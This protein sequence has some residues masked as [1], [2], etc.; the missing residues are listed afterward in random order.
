MQLQLVL[1]L[2]ATPVHW[3]ALGW[4]WS[5]HGLTPDHQPIL[6]AAHLFQG[7]LPA[8]LWWGMAQR[9]SGRSGECRQW[10]R[11]VR[12]SELQYNKSIISSANKAIL[13]T[14]GA[15][16]LNHILRINIH[17]VCVCVC[18]RARACVRACVRAR[19]RW[20]DNIKTDL[21]ETG[22]EG[23]EWP[24]LAHGRDNWWALVNKL[25]RCRFHKMWGILLAKTVLAVPEE[26]RSMQSVSPR[27]TNA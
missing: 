7:L 17:C 20:E 12:C 23:R 18:V 3:T 25:I 6:A 10:L 13:I 1:Q 15:Y 22:W 24:Y 4:C 21:K 14:K 26:L 19:H 11:A 8:S 16:G 27:L 5:W 2:T 9:F